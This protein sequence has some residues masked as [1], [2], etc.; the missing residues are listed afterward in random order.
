MRIARVSAI[1]A[2]SWRRTCTQPVELLIL[3]QKR[4]GLHPVCQ[5]S[6]QHAMCSCRVRTESLKVRHSE[7]T[8]MACASTTSP[9]SYS[10]QHREL[11]CKFDTCN[12]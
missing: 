6:V 9:H 3:F 10:A 8:S 1:G 4:A 2:E 12:L 7:R 5:G 11:Q